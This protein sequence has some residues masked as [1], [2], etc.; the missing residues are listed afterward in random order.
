MAASAGARAGQ[1]HQEGIVH[2]DLKP[3]NIF[4]V[5]ARGAAADRQGPR[6]RH[7]QAG[8]RSGRQRHQRPGTI[9]GTPRYMAPEQA[10]GA[11]AGHG[12]RG[13]LRARPDR[14]PPA[15]GPP[16]FPGR[17]LGRAAAPGGALGPRRTRARWGSISRILAFDAWFARACA[18]PPG[19]SLCHRGGTGGGARR[20]AIAARPS[21]R[22]VRARTWVAVAGLGA[23]VATIWAVAHT[24]TAASPPALPR[25]PAPVTTLAAPPASPPEALQLA[26]PDPPW[27]TARTRPRSRSAFPPAQARRDKRRTA[28]PVQP[29][30]ANDGV[31]DEP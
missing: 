12:G 31:W 9:L 23:L 19:R 6:L 29:R 5:R 3:E 21:G 28:A 20:R 1:A 18:V 22:R 27:R 17:Q 24:R 7:R 8:R 26:P 10:H 14:L 15:V 13:S 11:K 4:L 2:R 30:P 25:Q 16:L